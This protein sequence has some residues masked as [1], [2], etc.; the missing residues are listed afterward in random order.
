M[1]TV[2]FQIEGETDDIR[3][4]VQSKCKTFDYDDHELDSSNDKVSDF[5]L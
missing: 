2:Y 1:T 5:A 3:Q 4:H